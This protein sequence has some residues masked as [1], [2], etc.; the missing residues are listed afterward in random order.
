MNL[1]LA[2]TSPS[3]IRASCLSSNSILWFW[4]STT[5]RRA[6]ISAN[7]SLNTSSW[8]KRERERKNKSKIASKNLKSASHLLL[9]DLSLW[10]IAV[11]ICLP[12]GRC[13]LWRLFFCLLGGR[14]R[15]GRG[16]CYVPCGRWDGPGPRVLRDKLGLASESVSVFGWRSCVATT[17]G[18]Q[19]RW[20]VLPRDP[21][22]S[23]EGWLQAGCVWVKVSLE[24]IWLERK[25][26]NFISY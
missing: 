11:S 3:S 12:R 23:Q 16:S 19:Q 22:V 17:Q 25:Y 15:C 4:A 21:L 14:G 18:D 24:Q 10:P 8:K 1:P 2:H 26:G 5:A 9:T 7:S 13:R 20:R 6:F